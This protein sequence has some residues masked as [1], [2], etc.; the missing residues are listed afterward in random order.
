MQN[1][2]LNGPKEDKDAGKHKE[3]C[4]RVLSWLT[5]LLRN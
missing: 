5:G 2:L 4:H 1:L 3:G